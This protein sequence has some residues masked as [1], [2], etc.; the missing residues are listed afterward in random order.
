MP[1]EEE[2]R[3]RIL[4]VFIAAC[5]AFL[6]LFLVRAPAR[7]IDIQKKFYFLINWRMEPVDVPKEI[8]NT[9]IMGV[10]LIVCV[11]VFLCYAFS[12]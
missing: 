6:G 7:A 10:F 5:S 3:M 11:S 1:I 4:V 9:R 2:A 12:R 8:R